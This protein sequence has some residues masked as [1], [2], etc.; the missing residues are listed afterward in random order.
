M[1]KSDEILKELEKRL[2]TVESTTV[3]IGFYSQFQDELDGEQRLI[4]MQLRTDGPCVHKTDGKKSSSLQVV[5]FGV[6]PFDLVAH[7]KLTE[8]LKEIRDSLFVTT[9]RFN[10]LGGLATKFSETEATPFFEPK[11][12]QNNGYFVLPLTIEYVE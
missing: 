12:G 8:L 6:V 2:N 10:N 3:E 1:S 9:E 7:T 5:I 11:E 4:V